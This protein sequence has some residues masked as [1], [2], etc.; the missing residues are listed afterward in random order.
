MSIR[1]T[2]V[3]VMVLSFLNCCAQATVV[4][5]ASVIT[6]GNKKVI[7]N[8]GEK[9]IK[10]NGK[11]V[12]NE[13]ILTSFEKILNSSCGDIVFHVSEEYKAVITA[14]SN[15]IEFITT[16]VSN[17]ALVIELRKGSV[18]FKK[19]VIDVYCPELK[20]ISM[21][22]YGDFTS[23]DP[24]QTTKFEVSI[25]GFG[26]TSVTG[27]ADELK[28]TISGLGSFKGENFIANH[29]VAQIEGLGSAYV[30]ANESLNAEI[31]GLGR[32][33]YSGN[34]STVNKNVEGLGRIRKR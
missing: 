33:I 21:D 26:N 34:P 24:I 22:G 29:V 16:E 32:I 23:K 10:G 11:I 7:R 25:N 3:L 6:I 13:V 18:A 9:T 14:D 2:I 1:L 4:G 27:K 5:D 15:L 31:E 19:L 8:D 20:S 12:E 30:H 28:V 17:D